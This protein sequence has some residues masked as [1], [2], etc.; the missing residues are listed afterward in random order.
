MPKFIQARWSIST[1]TFAVGLAL[2]F[3]FSFVNFEAR[4]QTSGSTIN[5]NKATDSDDVI[6]SD[7]PGFVESS[8]VMGRGRFQFESGLGLTNNNQ[9]GVRETSTSLPFLLRYGSADTWELRLESDGWTQVRTRQADQSVSRQHGYT[10]LNLG[11][12]WHMQDGDETKAQAAIA[13]LAG[14]DLTTGSAAFRGAAATP[15]VRMVAEW[16]LP[17]DFSFAIMPGISWERNDTGKRFSKGILGLTLGH[18]LNEHWNAYVEL[19]GEQ[20]AAKHNGGSV[21]SYGA[22]VSCIVTR[23]VQIDFSMAKLWSG[24]AP[25]LQAGLGFSLRF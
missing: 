20:L 3:V 19:S 14:L 8:K 2:S 5:P 25:N 24:N 9:Q 6:S 1:F 16:E 15:S 13:W 23:D 11:L 18:A 21:V 7:R 12:K 17:Q 10:D 22:G 4:A